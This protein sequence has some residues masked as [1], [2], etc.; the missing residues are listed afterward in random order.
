MQMKS[1]MIWKRS[2]G[3]VCYV[4]HKTKVLL[5]SDCVNAFN[6]YTF[7]NIQND[8]ELYNI[9]EIEYQTFFDIIEG[10]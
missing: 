1:H 7:K 5:M 8:D 4:L 2:V 9:S 3:I 10:N 6:T